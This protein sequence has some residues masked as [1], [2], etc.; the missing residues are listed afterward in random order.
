MEAKVRVGVIGCGSIYEFELIGFVVQHKSVTNQRLHVC[1]RHI[2]RHDLT[3]QH[4]LT[5]KAE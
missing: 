3:S 2:H 4:T 5:A 1:K